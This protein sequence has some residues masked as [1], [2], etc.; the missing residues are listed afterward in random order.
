MYLLVF[1]HSTIR[2]FGIF[3]ITAMVSNAIT[4]RVDGHSI[5]PIVSELMTLVTSAPCQPPIVSIP[6]GATH[7]MKTDNSDGPLKYSRSETIVTS[8]SSKLN[9][10]GVL[11]TRY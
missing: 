1:H 6:A 5:L 2:Q 11:T 9:C 4:V 8:T 7:P 3:N 10:S